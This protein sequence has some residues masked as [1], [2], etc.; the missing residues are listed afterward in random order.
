[1]FEKTYPI[2]FQIKTIRSGGKFP[3]ISVLVDSMF[4]AELNNRI[5]TSGHDL[6]EIRGV[7]AFD[8][9]KSGERYLKIN[10]KEQELKKN[11][12][13][14]RDNEGILSSIAYGPARRTT[15]SQKTT[16]ALYYAW[17][18]YALDEDIVIAHLKEIL[19][20]LNTVFESVIS[21]TQ[22]VRPSTI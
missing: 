6:D 15:I 1:M 19:I 22:I 5:L 14:L 13:I 9:S 3:Q 17:C 8:V 7:P 16:N 2:K 21:E 18:P 12:V 20:N 4:L 10:G 11:D